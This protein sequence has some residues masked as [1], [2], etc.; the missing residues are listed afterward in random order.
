[1]N[2][3]IKLI[4][5]DNLHIKIFTSDCNYIQ[6][7]YKYFTHYVENYKFMPTYKCGSWDGKICMINKLENLIPYGLLFDYI[8][9]HKKYFKEY[10]LIIDNN[11]KQ[12][13]KGQKIEPIYDLKLE[14]YP[15]QKECIQS[16]LDYKKGII[17][18]SVS[19]G[20]CVYNVEIEVKISNELYKKKFT[21]YKKI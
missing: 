19:S 1:M 18:S 6:K 11:I 12:L 13:F 7:I 21:E 15:Y 4:L 14:P 10:E 5:H 20:K 17:R 3:K 16:C 8:R 9:I 2:K